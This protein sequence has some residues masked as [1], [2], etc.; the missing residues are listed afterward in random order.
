MTRPITRLPF[1]LSLFAGLALSL[2]ACSD[3]SDGDCPPGSDFCVAKRPEIDVQR[4]GQSW[5]TGTKLEFD[6]GTVGVQSIVSRVDLVNVGELELELY[7]VSVTSEPPGAFVLVP[8]SGAL[9]EAGAPVKVAGVAAGT[10]SSWSF[11]ILYTRPQGA[12]A[13]QGQLV[14]RSNSRTATN[15][16]ND[17]L[18]FQIGTAQ[19]KPLI[20]VSP[21]IADFGNVGAGSVENIDVK[22]FNTGSDP[23]IIDG[24]T[25]SGPSVFSVQDGQGI[26]PASA[27]TASEGVALEKPWEIA[28]A[29]NYSVRVK[30]EP[31]D[32][33]AAN[34]ELRFV[35]ND[36]T[37]A[38]L[39][40]LKGNVGGPCISISPKTVNFGGK[41]VGAEATIDVE[42]LSCGDQ[43][44]NITGIR[45][46]EGASPDFSLD[47]T[48]LSASTT[49][50]SILTPDEPAVSIPVNKTGRFTVK[51]IPDEV[52]QLVDGKPVPDLAKIEILSDTFVG[53]SELDVQGYGVEVECPTAIIKVA[54]GEEV[55]PQTKLHLNGDQSFASTGPI[56]RWEWSVEQPDGSAS[57]FLPSFKATNTTFEANVAGIYTF[58]LDV[59]DQND[60]KSCEPAVYTVIVNPDQAIHIEALWDTPGDPDQSDEGPEAGADVDL[61]FLHPFATGYDIDGDGKLDGWFDNPFDVYWFNPN[62]DW[63]A[64]GNPD[65]NPSLDRDDTDGAGPENINLNLPED[66]MVYRV[67]VHY[68]NDHGFGVSSV[69]VRIY[70]FGSLKHE[71]SG[72]E[73]SNHEFCELATIDWPSTVIAPIL[74]KNGGYKCTPNFEHPLFVGQ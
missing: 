41:L 3:S 31:V 51:F 2:G 19:S 26:W 27:E 16:A 17:N 12:S 45:L 28:P 66:G 57:F 35:S 46:L 47:L 69:T 50:A 39:V 71:I 58:R 67:G 68:W 6:I 73:M 24:F 9:P 23:L 14:V 18:T 15:T 74:G 34:G 59:W 52:N 56:A 63:G 8:T 72:L 33:Q 37:G 48:K 54:E 25:L 61:H 4:L 21:T 1:V 13:V 65:D 20:T 22:I 7:E 29:G 70:V 5:S 42:I 62:P 44:L 40:T 64:F 49:N 36:P 30:F 53:T 43:A 10:S 32:G 60:V 55:V 38:S 11:D